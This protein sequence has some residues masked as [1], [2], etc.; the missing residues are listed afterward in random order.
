MY[1]FLLTTHNLLRWVVLI[2]AVYVIV[3]AIRGV[4]GRRPYVAGDSAAGF[5]FTTS[6]DIQLLVGLL[7]YGVFSPVTRAAFADMGAAMGVREVRFFVAEHFVMML[8]AVVVAHMT[9]V[10][11][12]RAPA[13]DVKF[14]R[15]AIGSILALALI[16][17]GI[18]WWRP[19]LPA[20]GG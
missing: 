3:R 15:A 4:A 2:A 8:L 20:F 9:N 11:V 13:D 7:L 19:A 18:P 17:A 14:K 16:L 6:L 10:M 1:P 12:R 5:F